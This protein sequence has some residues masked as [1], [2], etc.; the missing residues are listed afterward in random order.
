LRYSHFL[1]SST[2]G[3]TL[4]IFELVAVPEIFCVAKLGGHIKWKMHSGFVKE[5]KGSDKT[6][7][8][9]FIIHELK[10]T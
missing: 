3:I 4:C 2:E 8:Q 9:N 10:T 1:G 5:I 7:Q 6:A